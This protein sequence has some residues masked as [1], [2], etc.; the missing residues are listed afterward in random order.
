MGGNMDTVQNAMKSNDWGLKEQL[1][2]AG[3]E[4]LS[5]LT[6][7]KYA[8]Q[9]ARGLN[10]L[11]IHIENER[12]KQQQPYRGERSFNSFIRKRDKHICYLCTKYIEIGESDIEHDIPLVRW[13][14][15]DEDNCHDSHHWCNMRKGRKTAREYLGR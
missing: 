13:G 3:W 15:T 5:Q 2:L 9:K 6:G 12:A 4:A 14:K 11:K 7:W 1:A 8:Y 10:D